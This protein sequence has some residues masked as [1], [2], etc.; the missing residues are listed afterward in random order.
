MTP[1]EFF[2]YIWQKWSQMGQDKFPVCEGQ[3][4]ILTN[5]DRR[6]ECS[7]SEEL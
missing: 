7:S 1:E 5:E 2:E 4:K 6:E 3:I